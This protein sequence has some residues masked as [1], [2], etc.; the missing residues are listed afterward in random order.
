MSLSQHPIDR[1]NQKEIRAPLSSSILVAQGADCMITRYY[2]CTTIILYW[3]KLK[4]R[5]E[6]DKENLK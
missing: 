2:M 3:R 6:V 1:N 5:E 4:R